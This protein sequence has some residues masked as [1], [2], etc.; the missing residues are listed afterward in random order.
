MLQQIIVVQKSGPIPEIVNSKNRRS[1]NLI[2]IILI[3]N[4]DSPK[5]KI[6]K[7]KVTLFKIGL[8]KEL[9]IP[10]TPPIKTK[11]CQSCERVM[12]KILLSPGM[13]FKFTSEINFTAKKIPKIPPK[14]CHINFILFLN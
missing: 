12:P 7:G 9:I 2:I 5:V 3:I 11:I 8:M 10:N 4:E 6:L 1:R 14:I 13:T